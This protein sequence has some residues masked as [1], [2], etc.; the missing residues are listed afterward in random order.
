ML[1]CAMKYSARDDHFDDEPLDSNL[2]G[3][4]KTIMDPLDPT[5]W[6]ALSSIMNPL[7]PNLAGKHEFDNGPL[8]ANLER[9]HYFDNGPLDSN[10]SGKQILIASRPPAAIQGLVGICFDCAGMLAR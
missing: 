8:D 10:L 4:Q 5:W 9:N 1:V 7:T 6:Q 3:K 2:A